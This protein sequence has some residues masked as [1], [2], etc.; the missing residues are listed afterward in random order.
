MD[1]KASS[2]QSVHNGRVKWSEDHRTHQSFSLNDKSVAAKDDRNMRA[3]KM[4][5]ATPLNTAFFSSENVKRIQL[6]LKESVFRKSNGQFV[7][8]NQD[9]TTLTIIMQSVYNQ[10]AKH[11]EENIELQILELNAHIAEYAV[12][13]IYSNILQYIQFKKDITSLPVPINRFE[14]LSSKEDKTLM[15]QPF[16]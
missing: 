8:G 6:L 7:I 5:G 14:N 16:L 3:R 9:D 11:S 12:P 13:V 4:H 2:V 10:H 15:F 1:S